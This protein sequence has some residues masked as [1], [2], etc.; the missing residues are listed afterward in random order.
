MVEGQS[1]FRKRVADTSIAVSAFKARADEKLSVRD[2][3]LGKEATSA[4]LRIL[5]SWKKAGV[6]WRSVSP[7]EHKS[8][9]ARF[10]LFKK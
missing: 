2:T 7:I 1:E 10:A 4:K 8:R 3:A 5:A 6:G 9:Q